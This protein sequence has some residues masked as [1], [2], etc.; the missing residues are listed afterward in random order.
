MHNIGSVNE[1]YSFSLIPLCN[2]SNKANFE[3]INDIYKETKPIIFTFVWNSTIYWREHCCNVETTVNFES[4]CPWISHYIDTVNLR[5]TINIILGRISYIIIPCSCNILGLLYVEMC[6]R[7]L[8]L[9]LKHLSNNTSSF[10]LLFLYARK[11]V[12]LLGQ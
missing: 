11:H 4:R 8:H 12:F 6:V 3:L 5:E 10:S 1:K 7:S 9:Y 2:Y